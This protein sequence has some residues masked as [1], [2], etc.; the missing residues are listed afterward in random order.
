MITQPAQPDLT[1]ADRLAHYLLRSINKAIREHEMLVDGDRVLVA[2]SGGKDS[3]SL[4][5]LLQRRQAFARERYALVA[6]HVRADMHCGQAVPSAWLQDW[7]AERSLPLAVE[8]IAIAQEL[9]GTPLSPCFRCAHN[10]RKALFETAARL[11]CSR[12]AFGHH[13]DDIAETTLMNLFYGARFVPMEPKAVLFGDTLTAIRPLAYVEER[14]LLPFVRASGY[15]IEGDPCPIGLQSRRAAV[16]RLLG[17]LERDGS[18]IKRHI[19][20]AV[21]HC[22]QPSTDADGDPV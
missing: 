16:K 12:V 7:C 14:D 13:A 15:P 19:R 3:L 22:R 11:G 10:R 17:E 8:S 2:V 6:C 18:E 1:R 20:S 5:D 4:L 21:E 9:A